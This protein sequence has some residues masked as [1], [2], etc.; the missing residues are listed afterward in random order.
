[1]VDNHVLELL[2]KGN[3]EALKK[4]YLSNKDD[5]MFFAKKYQITEEAILDIYQDVIIALMENIS[6]GKLQTLNSSL[7]TY[8]FSIGKYM[9]Y[10]YLKQQKKILNVDDFKNIDDTIEIDFDFLFKKELND[11]QKKLSLAFKLLGDKCKKILTLFYYR[12][13]TIEEITTQ[14]NYNN[15]DVVKSQ[16]SRCLK[17]LK[18]KITTNE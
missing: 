9:I 16:K 8:L 11:N 6:L 7:K 12:G 10:D 3:K 18:D 13:F 2:K 15:K 4:V 5:F 14:L 1:M 17:S